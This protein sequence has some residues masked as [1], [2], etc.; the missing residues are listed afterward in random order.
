M[1]L[2]MS[3]AN[4][5]EDSDSQMQGD[6]HHALTG[7]L[8][9]LTMCKDGLPSPQVPLKVDLSDCRPIATQKVGGR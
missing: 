2:V 3:S 4:S 1:L 6:S 7:K 8:P 9:V 5:V